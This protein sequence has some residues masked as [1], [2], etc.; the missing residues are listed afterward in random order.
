MIRPL[1]ISIHASREGGD[2]NYRTEFPEITI[3]IH[4]SREGGDKLLSSN[5]SIIN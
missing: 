3:S 2:Q 5:I 1:H 4:A